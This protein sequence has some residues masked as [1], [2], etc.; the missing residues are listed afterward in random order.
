MLRGEISTHHID[1][2]NLKKNATT[3]ISIEKQQNLLE[4]SV[5]RSMKGSMKAM[6]SAGKFVVRR[7]EKKPVVLLS[8]IRH[9]CLNHI[10]LQFFISA[11]WPVKKTATSGEGDRESW[12]FWQEH[13]MIHSVKNNGNMISV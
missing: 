8:Y 5:E 12:P 9:L 1:H 13:Y 4:T 11:K 6:W 7:K 3:L 2:Q 10:I